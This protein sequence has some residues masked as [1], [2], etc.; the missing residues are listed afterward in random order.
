MHISSI[1][2]FIYRNSFTNIILISV[3]FVCYQKRFAEFCWHSNVGMSAVLTP[4]WPWNHTLCQVT[5]P[6]NDIA[7]CHLPRG[8]KLQWRED[9]NN[10]Q[11]IRLT[12]TQANGVGRD[13]I[14]Y[15]HLYECTPFGYRI[16]P[17]TGAS[18]NRGAPH[19][20]REPNSE[21]RE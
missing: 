17:I 4:S 6:I 16:L 9:I 21:M 5:C 11:Y 15:R 1:I 7:A 8:S 3:A 19:S 12:N 13:N 2:L 14:I 18:P 20:L 10:A